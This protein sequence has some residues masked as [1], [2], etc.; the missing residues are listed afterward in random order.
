[1]RPE[2]RR[3]HRF[4]S[5]SMHLTAPCGL[6]R[7]ASVAA[8]CVW[9]GCCVA[10]ELAMLPPVEVIGRHDDVLG[11]SD[12]ASQGTIPRE[13]IDERPLLRSGDILETVPGMI[14]TQHSG[15]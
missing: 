7:A 10:Q 5:R 1:M 13:R 2:G 3:L 14:V 15:V 6:S 8:L 9:T 12:A 11:V 4:A